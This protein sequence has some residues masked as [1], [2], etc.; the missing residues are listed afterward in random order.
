MDMTNEPV[1]LTPSAS[2]PRRPRKRRSI[3]ELADDILKKQRRLVV[4]Q[5]GKILKAD[6]EMASLEAEK[7]ALANELHLARVRITKKWQKADRLSRLV[8][9][10]LQQLKEFHK[11]ERELTVKFAKNDGIRQVREQRVTMTVV[12]EMGFADLGENGLTVE[13]P[14]QKIR[15]S[16]VRQS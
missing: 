9:T 1:E 3:D 15:N 2:Q 5:V 13:A 4:A 6:R 10:L 14:A 12:G 7:K 8:S 16:D 11:I